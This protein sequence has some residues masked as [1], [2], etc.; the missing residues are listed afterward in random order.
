M[1]AQNPGDPGG[2]SG[3]GRW[4]YGPWFWPPADAKYPPI[5]N[6]YYGKDPEGPDDIRGTADDFTT[7]LAQAC[8][9]DD[10]AT[11]QYQTDPFCEPQLIPGTPNISAG[12]EQFNDTP[13]VNGTAYPTVTL[14]PK[15]YRLR[16]LNAA[17][18]RFFNFQWYVGDPT[19]ASTGVNGNGE[20]I[21]ATEVALNPAELAAAQ[22]DPVN[23]P[24]P[25]QGVP[26]PDRT[27]S[28][29]APRAAS[30]RPR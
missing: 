2:M 28:R 15:A 23:S 14:E 6:P 3:Y 4:M 27:G 7:D 16:M 12:M 20:V 9:L 22:T 17:N 13:I 24:T 26:R 8:N 5:P 18:D 1:P 30:C 21:G 25:V 11:W 19:T 10:P 29:S